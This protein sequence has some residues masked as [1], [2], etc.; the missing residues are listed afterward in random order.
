MSNSRPKKI[1][2]FFG[3]RP[4]AIKFVSLINAIQDN[5]NFELKIIV[6]G[7]HKEMLYQV[8][9]FFQIKPDIDFDLMRPDQTLLSFTSRCIEKAQEYFTKSL[10][11]VILVQGDTVSAY[12]GALVGFHLNIKVGHVEA[13][14]RSHDLYSP[15]P[16]EGYRQMISRISTY[17]FAP[18]KLAYDNLLNEGIK[19]SV[20]QCGNTVIDAL[21]KGTDLVKKNENA[22]KNKFK[23]IEFNHKSILVTAHRRESFGEP[24][25][26]ICNALLKIV[27][28]NKDCQIIFP[29]HL[30]PNVRS[31]VYKLLIHERIH[32]I[33][34]LSYQDL[35]YFLLNSYM[36]ITD[37]GGIQEEAPTLGKP[38][39]VIRDVTERVEG[40]I[41]GTAILVGTNSDK[42]FS[43]ANDILNNDLEY[44]KMAN[45]VNPYGDGNS[46]YKIL[47]HLN[48]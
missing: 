48:G 1:A 35:I 42:I 12:V 31:V 11:D 5:P 29:V 41:A 23:N 9:D 22:F 39:L 13:G 46:A 32:L 7:Q 44:E 15:F 27:N 14:L 3:T 4:E 43:K 16:E 10:P 18:T 47:E 45:S 8:L 6:T 24:F 28:E 38:V 17:H 20:F 33:E 19:D 40:I 25:E 26:R 34:P 36:V 37:S 21:L 30:N 2:C